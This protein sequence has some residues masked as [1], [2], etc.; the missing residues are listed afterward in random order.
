MLKQYLELPRAVHILCIGAFVN[1][2]GTFL[3]PF[4]TIYLQKELNLGTGFATRAMGAYGVGAFLA[5]LVG[6]HLADWI[7]RRVVMLISLFGSAAVLLVFGSLSSP[8]IIMVA[9]LIFALIA[10]MYRPAALAMIADLTESNRRPHAYGLMYVAVNLGFSVAAAVGG[11]LSQFSFQWLFWGDALTACVYGGLILVTIRETLPSRVGGLATQHVDPP[12]DSD[13]HRTPGSI[14]LSDAVKHILTDWTF[15]VYSL[16]IFFLAVTYIQAMST[17]PLYLGQL[18]ISAAGYGVI[19][20]LNGLMIVVLQLPITSIVVRFNR[21][22]MLILSALLTAVGFGIIGLADTVGQF[23][24]TVVVW[25]TGELISAPLM[26][27]IVSDLA[28]TPLRARY[29]GVCS[30]CFSSAM[31]VGAPIGGAVLAHLG[32]QYL[33]AGSAAVGFTAALAFWFV[34]NRIT[35]PQAAVTSHH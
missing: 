18:G 1:R 7:G 14:K 33:W 9:L 16:G 34:R 19:I 21:G 32:G 5:S 10:E 25:T 8:W 35:V 11:S 27:A 17:F 13:E 31:M 26:T 4:L 2:A 28:P 6:G 29:M 20:A 23:A 12:D 15:M 3:V 22:A 30:M 24:L